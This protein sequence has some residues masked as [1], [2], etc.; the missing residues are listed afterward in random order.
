M[1]RRVLVVD[2]EPAVQEML[3]EILEGRGLE[4]TRA[5]DTDEALEAY[6]RA[7]FEVVIA[8]VHLGSRS[9]I[10]LIDEI[11]EFDD[12]AT[13][14]VLTGDPSSN[15]ATRALKSGAY[16]YLVKPFATPDVIGAAVERVIERC[17]LREH[18]RQLL[19]QAQRNSDLLENL[20][21][22]LT[23][24]ANRD[25]LTGLFNRR[26]FLETLGL[27]LNRARRHERTRNTQQRG[28]DR[29]GNF[30]RRRC[31]GR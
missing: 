10:D 6:R 15:T 23:D 30:T 22:K 31:S 17:R 7:P 29:N 5:G 16:D 26:Y 21:G 11:R 12:E 20:S 4:V 1:S 13:V 19:D 14:V 8:D 9:G 27:E 28:L 2:D 24:I 18:N 3:A 25:A